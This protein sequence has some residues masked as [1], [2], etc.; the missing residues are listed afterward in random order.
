MRRDPGDNRGTMDDASDAAGRA[1]IRFEEHSIHTRNGPRAVLVASPTDAIRIDRT[2]LATLRE[3]PGE[4]AI[5]RAIVREAR[6]RSG[7]AR[8]AMFRARGNDDA[9]WELDADLTDEEAAEAGY[10]LVR[11][12]LWLHRKLMASGILAIVHVEL[13]FREV[14]ALREATKT[15]IEELEARAKDDELDPEGAA[16]LRADVWSLKHLTFY[17]TLGFARAVEDTL[18]DMIPMLEQRERTMRE[19]VESLPAGL[20]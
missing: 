15:M 9:A 6:A 7:R 14:D 18:P 4:S 11:S 5:D 20:V 19:L 13:G 12:H 1:P 10:L 16:V 2:R 8:L 17:F 3:G